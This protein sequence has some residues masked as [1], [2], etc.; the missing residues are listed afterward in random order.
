MTEI[1]ILMIPFLGTSAGAAMV[2]FMKEKMN[3]RLEKLLLGF[4]SGVMIAASVWSL[5]DPAIEMTRQQGGQPWLPVAVGFLLGIG[6]LLALDCA[7]PHLHP[8]GGKPEGV[9]SGF[10]KATMLM[11]AVSLHNLP[12]GMAVGV[13]LAGAILEDTGMTMAGAIVL[14]A[15]IAIQNFPEGAIISMPLRNASIS[16][17][18]AFWYG[19]A[20][21]IVEP[22]GAAATILLAEQVVRILP[23]LLAFAAGAMIYV[24]ADELIPEARDEG[25]TNFGTIGVALGFVLMMVLDVALGA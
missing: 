25:H 4:A 15:G 1:L 23:Y 10:D 19:V 21:G 5:L 7:V 20:S 2:F 12:E 13:A 8:E 16:R 17:P 18:R 6:F 11:L 22:V 3:S 24:V 14:T 9:K